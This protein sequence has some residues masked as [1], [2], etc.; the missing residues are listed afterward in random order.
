MNL[1][2]LGRNYNTISTKRVVIMTNQCIIKIMINC[3][4]ATKPM[5]LPF[6]AILIIT[7][8]IVGIYASS[9][10]SDSTGIR[11]NPSMPGEIESEY[12]VKN[13]SFY[14]YSNWKLVNYSEGDFSLMIPPEFSSSEV[15]PSDQ[16]PC[17]NA[18]IIGKTGQKN[19]AE[20]Q[21]TKCGIKGN[22]YSPIFSYGTE[23][24]SKINIDG[25]NGYIR[26]G[27]NTL[28]TENV[29]AQKIILQT[30]NIEYSIFRI[31]DNSEMTNNQFNQLLSSF[32]FK[33]K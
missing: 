8:V 24:V 33:D 28:E 15:T 20:I 19:I 9:L 32:K 23:G 14:D 3:C 25:F 31:L 18:I 22:T 13:M 26:Q 21:I 29:E 6:L 16:S 27:T 10:R 7:M 12:E 11:R 4:K 1:N 30:N 17:S 5:K 2:V